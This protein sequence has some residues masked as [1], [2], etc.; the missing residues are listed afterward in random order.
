M[1]ALWSALSAL[2]FGVAGWWLG[3]GRAARH[4]KQIQV[5]IDIGRGELKRRMDEVFS[6]QELSYLL[7]DTI[8]VDRIADQ[9]ARY[10]ARFVSCDGV[11]VAL[12]QAG[13][14]HLEVIGATG[15]LESVIGHIS[16]MADGSLVAMAVANER[17]ETASGSSDH[18]V[19]FMQGHPVSGTAAAAPLQ[20]HG[21][22]LGAMALVRNGG[23]PLVDADV[24]LLSTAAT[25]A[26]LALGNARFVELIRSGKVQW[27]ATFDAIA[28]GIAVI[29]DHGRVRRG[30][31]ALANLLGTEVVDLVAQELAPRLVSDPVLAADL[32]A[33][34][35][36]PDPTPRLT[37]SDLL[38]RV[39]RVT[40]AS[41]KGDG[42]WTVVLLED[43]TDQKAL[44]AS[45]IQN[46]KMAAVGQL[47]SGVAHELNN[48]LTSISGLTEFLL[49]QP[50]VDEQERTHLDVI[51]EQADRAAAIVR[52]LLTFARQGSHDSENVDLNDVV[53]RTAALTRYEMQLRD[54]V[55]S[56][57][58]D[59]ELPLVFG[60]R[61]QLQQVMLNLVTNAIQAV[62][63]NPAGR[64]RVISVLSR[65]A[66][67]TILL[68]VSDSG[69]GIPSDAQARVFDPFYT[70]KDPGEG[71]GL[72]LSITYGI[73][74]A[75]GGDIRIDTRAHGGTRFTVSLP[76]SAIPTPAPGAV[77]RGRSAEA[78]STGSVLLVDRDEAVR[79]MINL[80]FSHVGHQV[81]V[82]DTNTSPE[83]A[84]DDGAYDL[85]V[86]DPR[87]PVASGESF[88]DWLCREQ[89]GM[90]ARTIFLTADVREE[91]MEWL[92][93]IGCRFFHK[94]FNVQE[95]KK[96]ADGILGSA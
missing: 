7:A 9:V 1:I 54:V 71:T 69:P 37:R 59:P 93:G 77:P 63:K 66:K 89:P 62:G 68:E 45:V 42:A 20:A 43:V 64:E 15:S 41:L 74:Q 70:T 52:N 80:V 92:E 81:V 82:A 8:S 58:L 29:D 30:N 2:I 12:F 16:G 33:A 65:G 38:N 60:D 5:D 44:E 56:V 84:F 35:R 57:D 48:P 21:E 90:T 72:G 32:H 67:Q 95:L 75:H 10:V 3:R 55:F 24:R 40:P 86:A 6:L 76:S 88:A 85:I 34:W 26:A 4:L 17:L 49:Q 31:R 53:E 19:T 91:T 22:I 51:R 79:Q 13:P 28:D 14:K 50:Y 96:A 25:H 94:P 47:V 78:G 87:T 73:V 61:F 83:R 18:P 23:T 11:L 36:A 39:L 27:E 46:E